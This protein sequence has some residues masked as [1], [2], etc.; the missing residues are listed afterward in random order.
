MSLLHPPVLLFHPPLSPISLHLADWSCDREPLWAVRVE[1]FVQEQDVPIEEEEDHWDPLSL[2][3]LARTQEGTPVAC[4]RLL[5]DGHIGRLAVRAPWRGWGVGGAL[6]THLVALAT[7]A[8]HHTAKLSAQVQAI[9]FY[10]RY[11]FTAYGGVYDDVG[12]PHR[13]MKRAL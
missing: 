9:P 7:D 12:I 6:L 10:E 13:D 5:P 8:G 1:V 11:G 2:H 3:I 4:G